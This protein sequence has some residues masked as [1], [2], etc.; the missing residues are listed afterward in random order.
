MHNHI[1]Y[2][3][4]IPACSFV[5]SIPQYIRQSKPLHHSFQE[6]SHSPSIGVSRAQ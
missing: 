5:T 4:Y 2:I 1:L 3:L 6:I